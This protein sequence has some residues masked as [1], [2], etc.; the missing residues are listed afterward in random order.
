MTETE[1]KVELVSLYARI[2][3]AIDI[4]KEFDQLF[5]VLDLVPSE[6]SPTIEKRDV[7][8]ILETYKNMQ[9]FKGKK[10]G[11]CDTKGEPV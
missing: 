5:K 9:I 4:E 10:A 2:N 3:A 6:L 1:K 7:I 11:I 8:N